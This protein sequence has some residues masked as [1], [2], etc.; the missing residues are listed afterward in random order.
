MEILVVEDTR[1]AALVL[2][3]IL[4]GMGLEVTL[5]KNGLEAWEALQHKEFPV[6]ISDWMMPEMDGIELCRR[7]RS[8]PAGSFSY[9]I[10]LT[11]RGTREDKAE[12]I[13]AG[14]DDFLVKPLDADELAT[15]LRVAQRILDMKRALEA[16][17]AQLRQLHDQL[18]DQNDQLRLAAEV[19]ERASKRFS[20][21]FEGLPV[22]CFT[23][24]EE[25]RIIEWN[26]AFTE[27]FG[28]HPE[29]IF[30]KS[31]WE[32]M[33][34]AGGR[35]AMD[36]VFSGLR[37][38]G[39]EWVRPLPDGGARN[40]HTNAF[41]LRDPR[42][43][44]VG[45][46]CASIDITERRVLERRLEEQLRRA[47][48]LNAELERHKLELESANTQLSLRAVTD[49]LT[50]LNNHRY[51]QEMLE[52]RYDEAVRLGRPLSVVMVDVD[53]FK[54]YNDTYGH[55]AGDQVL[56]GLAEKLQQAVRDTDTVARYGGEEF[57]ALLPNA[58][59]NEAILVAERLRQSIEAG[60]WP[61]RPITASIGS[62]TLNAQTASHSQLVDD[63]D[64]AL[65]WSKKHG[66]NRVTH[67][68]QIR[69]ALTEEPQAAA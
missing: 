57:V 31:V 59:T 5:T 11:A 16:N 8:R 62:A 64:R 32:V 58:D 49:G 35:E 23:Y 60:P 15:R 43:A 41:P 26:G 25:G 37:M 55:P 18:A 24:N 28:L 3:R 34:P 47:S 9:L 7:I 66:R 30:E 39:V 10:L 12:A 50:G 44:V 52:R 67:A 22:A 69:P 40:L 33:S 54:Q 6:V 42:G 29:E 36:R 46:I 27:M 61:L 4:V 63:A 17:A 19:R 48:A 20:D 68:D 45:A 51:F 38:E 56:K 14:V 2:Q 13:E 21:L 1:V 53:F 65:Y